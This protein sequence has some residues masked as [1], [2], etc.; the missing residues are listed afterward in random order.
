MA[1]LEQSNS[2]L[3]KVSLEIL[4]KAQELAGKLT[5]HATGVILGYNVGKLA[6]E[7]IQF[8]ADRVLVVDSLGLEHYT[9]DAFSNVLSQLVR[10]QK[11]E[12]LLLGATND[13]RDLAGRLAVRLNTGLM[14]HAVNL[15]IQNETNLLVC[16]VPRF[17]GRAL[18]SGAVPPVTALEPCRAPLPFPPY[19]QARWG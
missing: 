7:A 8:G 6:E 13:G 18:P 10:D 3:A 15:E 16:G 17:A 19:Q 1:Y 14:S 11:P 12:I 4:G 9:T 2:Q 5:T